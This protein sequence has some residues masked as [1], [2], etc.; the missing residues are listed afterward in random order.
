[1]N[2]TIARTIK[3]P[4]I[5]NKSDRETKAKSTNYEKNDTISSLGP[6]QL[7]EKVTKTN[8]FSK[9]FIHIYF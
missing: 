4:I 2:E 7:F 5:D 1:M 3:P 9:C 8:Y 6:N